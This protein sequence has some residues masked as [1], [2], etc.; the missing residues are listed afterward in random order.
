MLLAL[1]VGLF[2][3][4]KSMKEACGYTSGDPEF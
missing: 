1:L 3:Y 2:D 4:E